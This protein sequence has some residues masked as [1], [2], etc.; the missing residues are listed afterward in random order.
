MFITVY[1]LLYVL[2]AS[3]SNPKALLSH[4]GFLFAPLRPYT[5]MGYTMTFRNPNMINGFRN[6]LFYLGVGTSINLLL[7][8]MGAFVL[9]R[10]HFAIRRACSLLILITMFFSGGMI[11]TFFVVRYLGLYDSRWA[12]VLPSAISVYNMIIMRTFF[13][14]IPASLE[15]SAML[16]GANDWHV[17]T[18][19]LLP[20]SMPVVAVMVLYYGVSHWNSWF[21]A[22]IYLRDRLK[23]PLQL[24]LREILLQDSIESVAQNSQDMID[25]SLYKELTQY[26]AIIVTTLPILAVYPF[27]QRYFVQGVMI[28]AVKG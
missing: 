11:P 18:R 9:S 24:F 2:F 17:F 8:S 26:C 23:Y 12:V 14:S 7:T 10:G 19:I 3:V 6:T 21:S 16:D 1:P 22:M 4:S 20:L 27:L 13:M 25:E 28:G 15:E 5:A